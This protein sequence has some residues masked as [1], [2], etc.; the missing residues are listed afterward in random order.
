MSWEPRKGF[1]VKESSLY[2]LAVLPREWI[3]ADKVAKNVVDVLPREWINADKVAKNVVDGELIGNVRKSNFG[4]RLE[5][6]IGRVGTQRARGGE[7][8]A[9]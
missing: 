6:R 5:Q 8:A 3:N 4:G 2:N 7:E 1:K 9:K